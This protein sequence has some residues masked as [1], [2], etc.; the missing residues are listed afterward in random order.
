MANIWIRFHCG[1]TCLSAPDRG[2]RP[3]AQHV[4]DAVRHLVCAANGRDKRESGINRD[5]DDDDG[6]DGDN[7]DGDNVDDDGHDASAAR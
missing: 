3:P 1:V 6:D 4:H 5:D 7:D 2:G